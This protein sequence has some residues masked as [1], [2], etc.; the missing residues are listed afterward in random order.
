MVVVRHLCVLFMSGRSSKAKL[1]CW[2][3]P[4]VS[5]CN[6]HMLLLAATGPVLGLL[7]TASLAKRG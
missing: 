1:A 7:F 3:Q 2:G 5:S 4:V 6:L